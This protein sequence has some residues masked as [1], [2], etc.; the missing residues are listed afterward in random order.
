MDNRAVRLPPTARRNIFT[1]HA[2]QQPRR[3]QNVPTIRPD[4]EAVFQQP[5]EDELVERTAE[6]EYVVHAPQPVYR[7]MA[8]VSLGREGQED[9]DQENE[10]IDLYGKPNAHWDAAAIEEE[11]K[12][13]LKSSLSRKVASLDEDN[14]MFRG[15]TD[16]GKK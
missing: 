12:V 5:A 14:W 4:R 10:L 8:L 9:I 7:N 15:E 2:Q 16:V 11:I 3:Q 1:T 13:A 6:G